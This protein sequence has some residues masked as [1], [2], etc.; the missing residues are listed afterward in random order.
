MLHLCPWE[1]LPSAFCWVVASVVHPSLPLVSYISGLRLWPY[2]LEG[3]IVILKIIDCFSKSVHDVSLPKLPSAPETAHL[4]IGHVFRLHGIPQDILED[5]SLHHRF[6]GNSVSQWVQ[7]LF[8]VS[9]FTTLFP[10]VP[11]ISCIESAHNSPTC[12]S[13][14]MSHFMCLSYQPPLFSRAS[15]GSGLLMLTVPLYRVSPWTDGFA[16]FL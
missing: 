9:L 7:P 11:R 15:G 2:T 6:A 8:V 14:G 13:T 12:S 1:V 4:L 3:N 16:F 5:L 10:G